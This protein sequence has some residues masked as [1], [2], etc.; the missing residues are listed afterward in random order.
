MAL[1]TLYPCRGSSSNSII[2]ATKRSGEPQLLDGLGR[3][4]RLF[5]V[6]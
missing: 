4:C 5:S 6:L 3:L 1:S 2:V